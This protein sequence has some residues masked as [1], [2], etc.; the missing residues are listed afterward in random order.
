MNV[1]AEF[2]ASMKA[3]WD[4]TFL[5]VKSFESDLEAARA[6][7]AGIRL[8][9]EQRQYLVVMLERHNLFLSH[10]STNAWIRQA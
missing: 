7:Q 5:N 3:K 1:L 9:G 8:R 4:E 10:A 6:T 2:E